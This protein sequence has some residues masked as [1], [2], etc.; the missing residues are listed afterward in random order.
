MSIQQRVAVQAVRLPAA[1]SQLL[2]P[3]RP[4]LALHVA[5]R[6]FSLLQTVCCC[7]LFALSCGVV[8][9][10]ASLL[11]AADSCCLLSVLALYVAVRGLC[12]LPA[13]QLL[14]ALC[15]GLPCCAA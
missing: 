12:L 9:G 13:N 7:L 4:V 14:L 8:C 11:L 1:D 2:P 3:L 6:G 15:I 10:I 5:L